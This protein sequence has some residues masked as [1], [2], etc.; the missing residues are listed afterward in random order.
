M[1]KVFKKVALLRADEPDV[2]GVIRTTK[3]L[4]NLCLNTVFPI[5]VMDKPVNSEYD[6]ILKDCIGVCSNF[7]ISDK[8]LYCDVVLMLDGERVTELKDEHK[9]EVLFLTPVF[10]VG[11][12]GDI[13]IVGV[14]FGNYTE[15]LAEPVNYM[16]ESLETIKA[17]KGANN[18]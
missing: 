3:E 18:A 14:W 16:L 9:G 10:E 12:I 5:P 15:M 11:G 4:E 8:V 17:G 13:T 2:C 6:V 1:Q 7:V